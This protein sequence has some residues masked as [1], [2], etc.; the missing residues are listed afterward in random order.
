M[1]IAYF[2]SGMLF[3]PSAN[4]YRL[5]LHYVKNSRIFCYLYYLLQI[6]AIICTSFLYYIIKQINIQ[7]IKWMPP[8]CDKSLPY[9]YPNRYFIVNFLNMSFIFLLQR[10]AFLMWF[11]I[12]EKLFAKR[13]IRTQVHSIKRC[14]THTLSSAPLEVTTNN[15]LL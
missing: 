14:I 13:Q 9:T 3:T 1:Q 6:V 12:W 5:Y 10:N 2:L 11:E 4:S 7:I 8:Y 15:C